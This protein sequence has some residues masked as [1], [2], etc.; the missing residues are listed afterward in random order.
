MVGVAAQLTLAGGK[1]TA[2]RVATTGLST[3]PQR[4]TAVEAALQGKAADV[5]SLA[6]AAEKATEGLKLR[7][8][9]QLPEAYRRSLAV[10]FT[11]RALTRA[12][13]RAGG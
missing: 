7:A 13:K 2:A 6:A 4:A 3:K 5:A 1:V 12:A 8:G 9:G 10:T 11:A